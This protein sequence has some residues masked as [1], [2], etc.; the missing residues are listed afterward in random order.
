MCIHGMPFYF[1]CLIVKCSI[2]LASTNI[3]NDA[4]STIELHEY[5][6]FIMRL[7]F[8]WFRYENYKIISLIFPKSPRDC[9]RYS[10]TYCIS[11][12]SRINF[13]GRKVIKE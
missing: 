6:V 9:R 7:K 4:W 1:M 5:E 12:V 8:L 3:D 2:I 11:L 13:D 10:L